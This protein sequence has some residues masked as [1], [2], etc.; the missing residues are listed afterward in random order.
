M[1]SPGYIFWAII[2][3]A[4]GAAGFVHGK[5]TGNARAMAIGVALV[6]FPYFVSDTLIVFAIGAALAGLLYFLRD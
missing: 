2:F 1:P 3:G 6:V 4:I 5:R